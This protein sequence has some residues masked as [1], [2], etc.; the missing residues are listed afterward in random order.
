MA[1][2]GNIPTSR[3]SGSNA[4]SP[5]T[6]RFSPSIRCVNQSGESGHEAPA[7]IGAGASVPRSL[8]M[9]ILGEPGS[10]HTPVQGVGAIPSHHRSVKAVSI[11]TM[12]AA[13]AAARV[14]NFILPTTVGL[15][16]V[17]GQI[18]QCHQDGGFSSTSKS[19]PRC[20]TRGSLIRQLRQP[21]FLGATQASVTALSMI[22]R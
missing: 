6:R 7:P 10:L 2:S 18:F 17:F 22:C 3:G 4:R 13:I 5:T 15:V 8:R 19:M 9:R 20:F 11:A 12:Q 21:Y 1:G 14:W 16:S